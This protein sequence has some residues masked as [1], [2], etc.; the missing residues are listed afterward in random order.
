MSTTPLPL[1]ESPWYNTDTIANSL[2]AD[3]MF[4][5]Y[6]EKVPGVGFVTRRRPGLKLFTDLAT[7]AQGDGLYY[8]DAA[9]KLIAVSNGKAFDVAS[10]GTFTDITTEA[11]NA[12]IPVVFS[13]GQDIAGVP[14]LYMATGK[15]VYS[16][17]GG[18]TT[19]P[20][21]Q[22]SKVIT[23][24]AT[25]LA[26]LVHGTTFTL[27]ATHGPTIADAI[28]V[29]IHNPT[30]NDY[31]PITAV[32][33]GTDIYDAAQTETVTLPSA[34]GTTRSTLYYK[35]VTSIVAATTIG[36]GTPAFNGYAASVTGGL[37]TL[38]HTQ[39]TDGY[40]RQVTITGLTATNHS[41][42]T[43]LITGTDV[44]GLAQTET[45]NLPNGAVQVTSTKY[46]KTVT[47]VVP[48]ASIGSDTMAIGW[49]AYGGLEIGWTSDSSELTSGNVPAATHVAFIKG[50]FLANE[51]GTN[52][53]DFTDT[54]PVTNLVD[55]TFWGSVD[56]PLTCDAKGD[57]L[58][59]LFAAW[60]EAYACGTGGIE[61]WQNDGI[62]PFSPI[63][64]AFSEGGIEAPYSFVV[65]DNTVFMLCV[66]AG[67][68][69]VIKMQ[70]RAPVVCSDAI[71]RILA[72]MDDV[73][74]A[75]GD[76]IGV[77]GLAMYLLT[78]PTAKQS[79]AYDYKNDVWVRWGYWNLAAGEHEHFI[80]QHSTYVKPWNKHLIMSRMDGKIYELDRST[81]NDDGNEMVS[82]RRTGWLNHGTY[83]RKVCDQFYVKCKAGA[84]N[85]GTLILRFRDEG[86]EEWSNWITVP[87]QPVGQRDFLAKMNRF[88]M[89]RS[90]QY[91]F[92]LTDDAD[93]VLV[94]VDT[95]LR[96]LSS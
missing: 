12:G 58:V 38:T 2:A 46:F 22:G 5:T 10:D 40:I 96:G 39:P 43:A 72:E 17:N 91:E 69:V 65:A 59:A 47:S 32:I 35:T 51:S 62:T 82:Y 54:N 23:A 53:F 6:L 84:S 4:D 70:G 3:S 93:L 16:I 57:K 79:W 74:D 50:S 66:I 49:N 95:E 56:N 52:R 36:D 63:P 55:N 7:G 18:N 8:W 42:K 1:N 75:I 27:S 89:Y 29:A 13:D 48:S 15:L 71:G 76:L 45:M 33:T 87:L 90:R 19:L 80:G 68:R 67:T 14:W 92:R 85:I 41:S 88:G 77:G 11:L 64:G 20:V 94:G 61:I 30:D 34:Q 44:N 81:F 21:Y 26:S 73:S 78:F 60:Q 9:N 24:N 37:W 83:N 86:N 28:I 25:G 31:S